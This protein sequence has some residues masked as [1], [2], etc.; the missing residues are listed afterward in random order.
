MWTA[1]HCERDLE[2]IKEALSAHP[3]KTPVWLHFQNSAGRRVTLEVGER[4]RVQRCPEL[5]HRLDRWLEE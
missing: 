2:E 4:F 5:D 3:G 1:R